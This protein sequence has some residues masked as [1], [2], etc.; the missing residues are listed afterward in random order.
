MPAQDD[1]QHAGWQI[2]DLE[3]KIAPLLSAVSQVH[4]TAMPSEK[5]GAVYACEYIQLT[6]SVVR[7]VGTVGAL[8]NWTIPL[9]AI[10][11]AVNQKDPSTI[12][13]TLTA[14]NDASLLAF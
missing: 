12:N 1:L 14:G 6:C 2:A 5:Y 11:A 3:K 10:F 7:L 13:P 9:T 8:A 4:R